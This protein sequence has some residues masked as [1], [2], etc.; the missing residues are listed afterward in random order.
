MASQRRWCQSC[1]H[2][3]DAGLAESGWCHH[4]KRKTSDSVLLMV[5]KHELAC[6]DAWSTSLWEP[7]ANSVEIPVKPTPQLPVGYETILTLNSSGHALTQPI[8]GTLLHANSDASSPNRES[9]VLHDQLPKLVGPMVTI[10]VPSRPLRV[11][12][13]HANGDKPTVRVLYRRLRDAGMDPWFDEE[14]LL[15]G[16]RWQE[17][18]PKAVQKTDVVIVCLS[19]ASVSKTGYV[20]R[21]IVHALDVAEEQPE[22]SIFLIPLRLEECD[23]PYRL[24]RYQWADYFAPHGFDRLMLSLTARMI[25]LGLLTD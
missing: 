3:Q 4:P 24:R 8:K 12:L 16:Q 23:V 10:P 21:E 9:T 14:K 2:F 19:M 5:R 13:C 7:I 20:Q 11:F 1:K 18:I 22:G 15:P 25:S 17:E 6:R